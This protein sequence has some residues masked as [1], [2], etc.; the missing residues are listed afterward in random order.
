MFGGYKCNLFQAFFNPRSQPSRTFDHRQ[1][2]MRRTSGAECRV[3][4]VAILNLSQIAWINIKNRKVHNEPRISA[5]WHSSDIAPTS[6]AN[7]RA[8][9][10]TIRTSNVP[11]NQKRPND[12]ASFVRLSSPG[13]ASS[14]ALR[15]PRSRVESGSLFQLRQMFSTLGSSPSSGSE[16]SFA[17]A[18]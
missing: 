14:D 16:P 9:W 12:L 4:H 10:R 15:E 6:Q 2:R 17:S 8:S 18:V 11:A 13:G 1:Q 5:S 3:L 7:E